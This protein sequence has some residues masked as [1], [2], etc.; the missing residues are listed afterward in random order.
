M[1]SLRSKRFRLVSELRRQRR[2]IFGFDRTRNETRAPFFAR[3]LTLVPC[4]KTAQ[5]RLLRRLKMNKKKEL[6]IQYLVGEVRE[7][8]FNQIL[9]HKLIV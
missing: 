8:A 5:K 2:G 9:T 3:S 6:H 4:S 1:N 7:E